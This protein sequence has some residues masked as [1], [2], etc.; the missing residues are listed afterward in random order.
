MIDKTNKEGYKVIYGDTDGYYF[1]L[2]E[3]TKAET[4]EFLKK[5]NKELPGSMELELEDFYKRGI[6]TRKKSGEAGAK[7]KY[8]LL[9]EKGKMKIRGFET[10]RR[11]WCQLARQVQNNILDMILKS[12]DEKKAL[13]YIKKVI[14]DLKE[15]R[16]EKKQIIIRTQLKKILAEYKAV[17]P[18]VIAAQKIKEQGKPIDIGMLIEYFIAE[19]REKKKLVRDKVKLPDEKGEYNID[20]YLN[21]QI[22]PAVEN[23]FEVFNVNIKEIADGKKQ[24]KL[25]DF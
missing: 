22:I 13:E 14:E 11:D 7:K 21:N 25:G 19:T 9:D 5:L 16:I 2:Q 24:K 20:Y 18:H 1:L 3:K 8:A 23:I 17:T 4:L 6:W 15:R 10:V 12:G